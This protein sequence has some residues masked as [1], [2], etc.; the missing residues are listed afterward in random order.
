MY[1]HTHTAQKKSKHTKWIEMFCPC[2]R[3][4]NNELAVASEMLQLNEIRIGDSAVKWSHRKYAKNYRNA[5]RAINSGEL[6][7]VDIT[8]WLRIC[9]DAHRTLGCIEISSLPGS[10][11][12]HW[13][14]SSDSA[15]FREYS[16]SGNLENNAVVIQFAGYLCFVLLY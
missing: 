13:E 14:S 8:S 7:L 15:H 4:R 9:L 11:W 16:L 12:L 6:V 10:R 1:T 5:T 2:D 3:K